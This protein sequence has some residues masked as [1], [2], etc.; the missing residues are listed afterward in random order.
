MIHGVNQ[1]KNREAYLEGFCDYYVPPLRSYLHRTVGKK[2]QLSRSELDDLLQDF[3]LKKFLAAK[4]TLTA[5]FL[6]KKEQAPS[7]SFRGYLIKSVNRF[8]LDY[9]RKKDREVPLRLDHG[10][11]KDDV[12]HFAMDWG[13]DFLRLTLA[14]MKSDCE[15][16]SREDLWIAFNLRLVEPLAT[17]M[18]PKSLKEIGLILGLE[19][20]GA[21]KRTQNLIETAKRRFRQLARKLVVQHVPLSGMESEDEIFERELGKLLQSASKAKVL[22]S[23]SQASDT[24]SVLQLVQTDTPEAEIQYSAADLAAIWRDINEMNLEDFVAE[25]AP[26]LKSKFKDVVVWGGEKLSVVKDLWQHPSPPTDLLQAIKSF[27][28]RS[29]KERSARI[30]PYEIN[31]VLYHAAIALCWVKTETIITR[32]EAPVILKKLPTVL[33][34]DWLDDNV[35]ELFED[36]ERCLRT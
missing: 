9:L 5:K 18:K 13:E 34:Y 19:E 20:K 8:V 29:G 32:D 16:D 10:A 22:S 23:P 35:R 28:K 24:L 30:Y 15:R 11:E 31:V 17:S 6:E 26:A 1:E 25:V 3:L 27:A 33:E 12:D 7:T 14:Q 4:T 36:W 2:Y 21:A